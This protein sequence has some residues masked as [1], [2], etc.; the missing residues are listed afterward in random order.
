MKHAYE[1]VLALVLHWALEAFVH[2]GRGG[3]WRADT[4]W[5]GESIR[6]LNRA[7]R[8]VALRRL[9]SVQRSKPLTRQDLERV[10]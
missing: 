10:A 3:A 9:A 2:L 1:D 8:R 5:R 6:P 4:A 7:A